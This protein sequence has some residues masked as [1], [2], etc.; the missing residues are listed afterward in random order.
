MNSKPPAAAP[1]RKGTYTVHRPF[2]ALCFGEERCKLF[3]KNLYWLLIR[4][5][6][7]GEAGQSP[8]R[9]R[10]RLEEVFAS[11]GWLWSTVRKGH[12]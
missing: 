4:R 3:G 5:V 11:L 9:C 10:A 6:E 2:T 8:H 12:M 7:E 1:G